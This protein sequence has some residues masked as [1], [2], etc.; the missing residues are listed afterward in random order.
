MNESNRTNHSSSASLTGSSSIDSSRLFTDINNVSSGSNPNPGGG[1][2][3][4]DKKKREE[5]RKLGTSFVE[6]DLV[7][8]SFGDVT[9]IRDIP[10]SKLSLETLKSFARALR[11]KINSGITKGDLLKELGNYKRLGAQRDAM[12]QAVVSS[13][14]VGSGNCLPSGLFHPDGT[15]F[16]L[17]LTILDPNNR[18]CYMGTA[19]QISRG[20][21][22]ANEKCVPNYARLAMAYNDDSNSDYDDAGISLSCHQDIYQV[23]GIKDDTPSMFDKLDAAKFAQVLKFVH[24]KYRIARNNNQKSGSHDDFQNFILGLPWILFY[25]ERMG[26]LGD[27]SS[28]YFNIAYPSLDDTVFMTSDGMTQAPS[29]QTTGGSSGRKGKCGANKKDLEIESKLEK[30]RAAVQKNLS[31]SRLFDYTSEMQ[32]RK[33]HT[34][35]MDEIMNTEDK[36]QEVEGSLLA[37]DENQNDEYLRRRVQSLKRKLSALSDE[38]A[39]LSSALQQF[40]TNN[41]N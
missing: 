3:E 36:L 1:Q 17:I 32:M 25:H 24:K 11:L 16:R 35:V 29:T 37:G 40:A 13:S 39:K 31:C 2:K 20:E 34:E 26:E 15:I 10:I 4:K 8:D 9:M 23:Y 14:S 7:L 22:G 6:E 27:D 12:K 41:N 19:Q 33:R 5:Q 30:D 38:D 18:E 28:L 21:L